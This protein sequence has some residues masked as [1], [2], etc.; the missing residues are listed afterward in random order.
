MVHA[1]QV[2]DS[3]ASDY[4]YRVLAHLKFQ[5]IIR[6]QPSEGPLE[7]TVD[8][9]V[10]EM[11]RVGIP[12]I[13][14]NPDN[15]DTPDDLSRYMEYFAGFMSAEEVTALPLFTVPA[16]GEARASLLVDAAVRSRF[17]G[18]SREEFAAEALWCLEKVLGVWSYDSAI[19]W[20]RSANTNL[21]GARPIE[22]LALHG[23]SAVAS[24]LEADEWGV[25]T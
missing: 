23:P 5:A 3:G 13:D 4:V 20:L 6:V 12:I 24:A 17:D 9:F 8:E 7:S 25:F 1:P 16:G 2:G 21:G 10:N 11:S 19:S 14:F 22:V 18:R 15:P